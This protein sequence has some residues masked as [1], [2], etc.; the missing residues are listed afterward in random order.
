M[1]VGCLSGVC[2][3]DFGMMA[4]EKKNSIATMQLI[5]LKKKNQ[6]SQIL[7]LKYRAIAHS[8]TLLKV[9]TAR[10][11]LWNDFRIENPKTENLDT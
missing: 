11:H 1:D 8:F 4:N 9:E 5:K 3:I 6:T 7:Y 2:S 10:I